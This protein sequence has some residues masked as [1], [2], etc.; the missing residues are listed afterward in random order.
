MIKMVDIEM[1]N[2][3]GNVVGENPLFM[4]VIFVFG[5][6]FAF[7]GA[8]IMKA[9]AGL[10]GAIVGAT[11]AFQLAQM[12]SD[13]LPNPGACTIIAAIIGGLIGAYLGISL[14][15][16]L[17]CMFFGAI[18]FFIGLSF[19]N[20]FIIAIIVGI[21]LAIIVSLVIEQFLA[22]ITALLGGLM[23]GYIALILIAPPINIFVF[24]VL[25]FV[26]GIFG[27]KYQL[28]QMKKG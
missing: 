10:V 6:V 13:D 15:K 8:N 27:A 20:D 18:G 2:D 5:L 1:F 12:F 26:I 4:I 17:I 16:A 23:I 14:M 11:F 19:T 21:I 25:T 24:I 22:I 3:A 28:S 9:I 7:F